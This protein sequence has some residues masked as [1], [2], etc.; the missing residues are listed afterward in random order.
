[1]LCNTLVVLCH[2]EII[3]ALPKLLVFTS[4]S[5]SGGGSGFE[6]L[7][8]ASRL[9]FLSAEIVAV[10]SN[11]EKGGVREKADRLSGKKERTNGS[12]ASL[13]KSRQTSTHRNSKERESCLRSQSLTRR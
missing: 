8:E 9:G 4:G 5:A 10:V 6:K 12:F 3:V 2:K 7:A 1:M 13:A 11:L